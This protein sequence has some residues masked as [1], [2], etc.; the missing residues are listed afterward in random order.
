MPEVITY[1]HAKGAFT[2]EYPA[3]WKTKDESTEGMAN[4][5]FH[6]PDAKL[7]VRIAVQAMPEDDTDEAYS[8]M[9]SNFVHLVSGNEAEFVDDVPYV[10]EELEAL[11]LDFEFQQNGET[12][13]ATSGLWDEEP[14]AVL[15]TV[16]LPEDADEDA[17]S[18][19]FNIV[20]AT[21]SDSEASF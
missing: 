9:L 21:E 3:G 20:E 7:Q 2:T 18:I 12:F 16:S 6:S 10:D 15:Y 14:F 4:V 17:E 13:I 11:V 19:L 1:T 5:L 8:E